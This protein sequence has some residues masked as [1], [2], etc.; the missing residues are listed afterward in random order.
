MLKRTSAP[1]IRSTYFFFL[2]EAI[3]T[4]RMTKTLAT[5]RRKRRVTQMASSL[6]PGVYLFCSSFTS[7][8]RSVS[9]NYTTLKTTRSLRNQVLQHG[10]CTY[11]SH[12]RPINFALQNRL[13]HMLAHCLFVICLWL[14]VRSG[15]HL[16]MRQW[17]KQ[18]SLIVP[19]CWFRYICS[20][21]KRWAIRLLA[22][23]LQTWI[24]I[25]SQAGAF[26]WK[27]EKFN[28]KESR[29]AKQISEL[30]EWAGQ[31]LFFIYT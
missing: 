17:V 28:I 29:I 16:T 14:T 5:E 8:P 10:Y 26:I 24:K 31:I 11:T 13:G 22:L 25:S 7:V 30:L 27:G 3:S 9:I 18:S 6:R 21:G 20:S 23:S 1:S 2:D 4:L 15:A 19:P 12:L